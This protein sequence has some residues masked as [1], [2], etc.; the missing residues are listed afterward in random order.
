MLACILGVLLS[1][2]SVFFAFGMIVLAVRIGGGTMGLR[3]GLVMFRRFVVCV[4]H[5][6]SRRWPK[7]IGAPSSG[8]KSGRTECQ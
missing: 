5:L 8:L 3:C 2:G 7:N 1:L 6:I 4:F